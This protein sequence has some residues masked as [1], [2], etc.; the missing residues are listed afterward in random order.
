MPIIKDSAPVFY[1]ETNYS[2]VKY[3]DITKFISLLQRKSLFFCRLDKLED[4]FEGTT[5]K[6]NFDLRVKWHQKMRDIGFFTVPMPD[7]EIIKTVIKQYE[8][9]KMLKSINCVNCWNKKDDESAALWKIYS[10]F[11]KGIMIKS[12]ITQLENSLKDVDEQIRL[13]EIR[14]INYD[15]EIMPDGNTMYPLIHKQTAYAYEDEVRLIH[16]TNQVGWEHD[17][18]KEEV[19][20]GIYIQTDLNEL[21]EEINIGPY[22]PKWFHSLIQDISLK[23]GLDKPIYKSKLSVIEK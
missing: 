14:Y 23:Y 6:A 20:E 8:F 4:Q 7:D 22:S 13:S 2:I 15:R 19:Q 11:G 5:A 1:P 12:S 18:S 21:I 17:W 10:D 9:E 3:L 16:E